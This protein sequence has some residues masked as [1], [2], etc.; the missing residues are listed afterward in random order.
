CI[1]AEIRWGGIYL[2]IRGNNDSI[3]ALSRSNENYRVR[4]Q[5]TNLRHGDYRYDN[6]TADLRKIEIFDVR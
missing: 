1:L 6:S 5:Y 4:V 2:T 3:I